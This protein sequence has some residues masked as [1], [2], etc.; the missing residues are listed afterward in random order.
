MGDFMPRVSF[1]FR[2]RAITCVLLLMAI[3]SITP[4]RA[5]SDA[6]LDAKRRAA[7]QLLKDGKPSDALAL[8]GEITSVDDS[9]YND[10]LM[11]ARANEKLGHVNEAS[12]H[13]RRVMELLASSA[14]NPDERAAKLEADKKLK[15][16]DPLAGKVD[17]I[18]DDAQ[19]KLDVLERDAVTSHNMTAL[20]RIFRLRGSMWQAEKVKDRGYTEV[21]SELRWQSSGFELKEKQSYHLR[22]AG[23]WRIA[24]VKASDG[25]IECTA[26]GSDK[27]DDLS[28]LRNGQL[29]GQVKGKRIVLGEDVVFTAPAS[30]TLELI[31]YDITDN[32]LHKN[33]GSIAV[34][35]ATH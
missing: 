10:H 26:A 15:Q 2:F 21:S 31:T 35:V 22:A 30:G 9:S 6:V 33:R 4:L 20:A 7:A 27:R 32:V 24:G 28:G 11:M 1:P 19:K 13:Y 29:V 5:A 12:I 16:I 18:V 17:A 3:G 34:L 8:L 23:T 14:G 25:M